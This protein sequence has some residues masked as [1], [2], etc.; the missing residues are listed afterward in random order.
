VDQG[1]PALDEDWTAFP[2]LPGTHLLWS[3]ASRNTWELQSTGGARWATLS[4]P[5]DADG[6]RISVDATTFVVREAGGHLRRTSKKFQS[7]RVDAVDAT[8]S[9]V[10]SWK[11]GHYSRVAGTHLTVSD[12]RRFSSHWNELQPGSTQ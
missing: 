10:I 8:G 5:V 4:P 6:C 12:G 7:R 3:P 2:T 11:G 9:P 1:G